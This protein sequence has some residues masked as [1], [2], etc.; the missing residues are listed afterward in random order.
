MVSVFVK[1]VQTL[2]EA[3]GKLVGGLVQKLVELFV[4]PLT[5]A[6][7]AVVEAVSWMVDRMIELLNK[8][9]KAF[10]LDPIQK[11]DPNKNRAQA[12]AKSATIGDVQS[13]LN[14]AYTSSA[15]GAN[16]NIPKQ[17]L[18]KL[19]Q[20][21]DKIGNLPENIGK[22]MGEAFKGAAG[23]NQEG[24]DAEAMGRAVGQAL[25]GWLNNGNKQDLNVPVPNFPKNP[26]PMIPD[27]VRPLRSQVFPFFGPELGAIREGWRK[28]FG[29]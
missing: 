3:V 21:N 20:I 1:V 11:F 29:G 7:E 23:R 8:A 16:Q 4:G 10:G 2:V 25:G 6:I 18:D 13:F 5:Q 15:M 24:G 17:Q 26:L 28:A 14:R 12:I 22:A 9:R 27:I 19:Q